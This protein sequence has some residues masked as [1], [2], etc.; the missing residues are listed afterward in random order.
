VIHEEDSNERGGQVCAF[1]PVN[2]C[3]SDAWL[4]AAKVWK[5]F[6]NFFVTFLKKRKTNLAFV[7][8][9]DYFCT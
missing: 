5:S 9:A 2:T 4:M 8:S 7:C 6:F 3:L 1:L